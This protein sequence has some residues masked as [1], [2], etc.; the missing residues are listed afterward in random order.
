LVCSTLGLCQNKLTKII[1][2]QPVKI[3][4]NGELCG[5]CETVVQYVDSLL[6]EN[7]TR[8]EIKQTLEKVCNFLPSEV[9]SEC[10]IFIDTYA[11]TLIDLLEKELTP[12]QVCQELGLCTKKA[13]V[14]MVEI[15]PAKAHLVGT[16]E[17]TFGPSYWCATR[18]N[19]KKCK[20]EAHCEK[21]GYMDE[22]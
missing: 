13:M 7:A 10:N 6:Q 2:P 8:E 21:H 19:A 16:N 18:E 5:V 14:P 20:T 22:K 12:A 4:S 9:Q 1:K 15:V 3:R 11:A 17:C